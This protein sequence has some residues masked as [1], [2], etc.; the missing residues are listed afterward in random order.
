MSVLPLFARA[1][2]DPP[3]PTCFWRLEA[4][5]ATSGKRWT[6]RSPSSAMARSYACGLARRTTAPRPGASRI[7]PPSSIAASWSTPACRRT[8]CWHARRRW[9]ARSG[10]TAAMNGAG[11][12]ARS[13]SISSPMRILLCKSPDLTLPHPRLFER[14]FVLVPLTEI[15]PQRVIC[16][17]RVCDALAQI[18]TRGIERLPPR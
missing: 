2:A 14:G 8:P 18:D 4:T 16:G 13:I 7:S 6:G 1:M 12:P 15:A 3:C 17:K 5:S 9:S 10:A 11:A